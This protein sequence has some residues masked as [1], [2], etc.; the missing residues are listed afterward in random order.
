MEEISKF[1]QIYEK[2]CEGPDPLDDFRAKAIEAI[3]EY[4]ESASR[5]TFKPDE[6]KSL[7]NSL[8]DIFY[9][10]EDRYV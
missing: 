9:A 7:A 10:F 2:V 3:M 8:I 4:L 5:R 1:C 6:R